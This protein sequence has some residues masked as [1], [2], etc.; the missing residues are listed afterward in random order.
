MTSQACKQATQSLLILD[1]KYC[2]TML[3][4][5]LCLTSMLRAAGVKM[6]RLLLG[7]IE[8]I[9]ARARLGMCSVDPKAAAAASKA[10]HGGI[11]AKYWK[12]ATPNMAMCTPRSL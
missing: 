10:L 6:D 1:I 2:E 12:G 3:T 11:I 9:F 7:S 8:A 4:F 5:P